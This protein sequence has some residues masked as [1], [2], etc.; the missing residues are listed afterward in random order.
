MEEQFDKLDQIDEKSTDI[1]VD[2]E[3][4]QDHIYHTKML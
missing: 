4:K 3:K 2:V 1:D